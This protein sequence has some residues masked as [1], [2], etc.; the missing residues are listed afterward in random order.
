MTDE[1][2]LANLTQA[3]ARRGVR[4]VAVPPGHD[5]LQ[6]NDLWGSYTPARATIARRERLSPEDALAIT[7]HEAAHYCL[8]QEVGD[9]AEETAEETDRLAGWI[10][11]RHLSGYAVSWAVAKRTIGRPGV[12]AAKRLARWCRGG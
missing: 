11:G 3:L 7:V 5:L 8:V 12:R 1:A 9:H 10:L 6:P 4:V 2:L